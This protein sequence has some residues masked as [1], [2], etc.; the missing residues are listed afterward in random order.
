MTRTLSAMFAAAALF[1]DG[2]EGPDG[3]IYFSAD[4]NNAICRVRPR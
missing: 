4:K 3:T 1:V 2:S